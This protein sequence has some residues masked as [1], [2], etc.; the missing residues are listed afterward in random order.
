MK[1]TKINFAGELAYQGLGVT[2]YS[3]M[4]D[5]EKFGMTYGCQEDCPQLERGECEIYKNVETYNKEV[6][7]E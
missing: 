2:A 1:E 4:T 6:N 3:I 7:G 5:C